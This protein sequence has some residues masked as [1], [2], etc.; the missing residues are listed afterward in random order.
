MS[1]ISQ[2]I[3]VGNYTGVA[4]KCFEDLDNYANLMSQK[5][6]GTT[7]L[8][9]TENAIFMHLLDCSVFFEYKPSENKGK[10]DL[11]LKVAGKN[12]NDTFEGLE[13]KVLKFNPSKTETRNF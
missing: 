10:I 9:R 3:K 13:D 12:R 2:S 4:K 8:F 7:I 11:T 6:P 5:R 1:Y